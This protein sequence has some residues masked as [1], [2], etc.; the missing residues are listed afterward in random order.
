[1]TAQHQTDCAWCGVNLKPG[2][3]PISH[4]ICPP[5]QATWMAEAGLKMTT[6]ALTVDE[7][8][9]RSGQ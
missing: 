2:I 8:L 9:A 6:A 3:L 1:M 4:G 5:C 7:V